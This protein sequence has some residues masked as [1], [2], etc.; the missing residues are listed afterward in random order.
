MVKD[1]TNTEKPR[2]LALKYVI[3]LI[4]G[5]ISVGLLLT[6]IASSIY[7]LVAPSNE[8]SAYA[9][10][11]GEA[12]VGI[13]T[14]LIV[15]G[16]IY[17]VSTYLS[18][19]IKTAIRKHTYIKVL[20]IIFASCLAIPAVIFLVTAILPLVGFVVGTATVNAPNSIAQIVFSGIA[21][22]VL[23]IMICYHLGIYRFGRGIHV[24]FY[25]ALII[26]ATALYAAFPGTVV[27]NAVN[28]EQIINDLTKI[29][30]AIERYT[31]RNNSLPEN[32]ETLGNTTT[33]NFALSNYSYTPDTGD[34]PFYATYELCADN[35]LIDTGAA[36]SGSFKYH[37]E[38]KQCFT[39]TRNI[40]KYYVPA[41]EYNKTSESTSYWEE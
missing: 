12:F 29:S 31:T 15:F 21:L 14:N 17:V 26:A 9:F 4:S 38:G 24:A 3:S 40:G 22:I 39:R 20:S 35:F 2:M 18:G 37:A 36:T 19:D 10:Q 7:H 5:G 13:I 16:A 41:A 32:L 8:I 1:K 34:K 6:L 30:R 27:R 33:L 25:T 28:D 23:A 11:N